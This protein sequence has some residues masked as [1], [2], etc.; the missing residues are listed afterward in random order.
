MLG[1]FVCNGVCF[2]PCTWNILNIGT[3]FTDCSLL[4]LFYSMSVPLIV[5]HNYDC[6][7]YFHQLLQAVSCILLLYLCQFKIYHYFI[8]LAN[9]FFV[10]LDKFL[11]LTQCLKFP[12]SEI[13]Y[14]VKSWII[15]LFKFYIV[16][17][18]RFIYLKTG[19][20]TN[21]DKKWVNCQIWTQKQLIKWHLFLGVFFWD[22]VSST[23]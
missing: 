5:K 11:A 10:K 15:S 6:T 18:L 13:G 22:H 19:S 12:K 8:S 1:T 14:T 4:L 2:T 16:H 21:K 23:A 9:I 17:S 20:Q 7:L 3:E